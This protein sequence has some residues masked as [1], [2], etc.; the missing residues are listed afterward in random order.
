MRS[1]RFSFWSTATG[2]SVIVAFF[3]TLLANGAL[4]KTTQG[5]SFDCK[6]AKDVAA[7]V[8]AT[9][10]LA[11]ADRRMAVLYASVQTDVLGYGPSGER[12]LQRE[13]LKRLNTACGA[14]EQAKLHGDQ[15]QC[16]QGYY[17]NRLQE[18]AVAAFL[19]NHYAAM[20]EIRASMPKEAPIYDAIYL[21]TTTANP[22]TRADKVAAAIAPFYATPFAS[23]RF[24]NMAGPKTAAGAAGSDK[25]FALFVQLATHDND[26]HVEWP[27]AVLAK[28]PGLIVGLASLYGSTMDNFLPGSDCG[29]MGPQVNVFSTFM[30]ETVRAAPDCGGTLRYAGYREFARME[31]AARLH[32]PEQWRGY[33][34]LNEESEE[35]VFRKKNAAKI[36]MA[37]NALTALYVKAFQMDAKSAAHDAAQITD[38][39]INQAYHVC[40]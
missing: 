15:A 40:L 34:R 13:W 30:W 39:M 2:L 12:K 26:L 3:A 6:G 28:R 32:R 29:A 38:A 10:D 9:P 24:A 20:A 14:A 35:P 18:L 16:I 21:Y 17:T 25:A 4:A 37:Q 27:C 36:V 5:P 22:K 11:V 1:T 8:C 23:G 19:T 33:K 7:M 31:T